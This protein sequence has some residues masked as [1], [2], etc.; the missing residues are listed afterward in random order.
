MTSF[1]ADYE[2]ILL[3]LHLMEARVGQDFKIIRNRLEEMKHKYEQRIQ[4][5]GNG[6]ET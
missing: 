5:I 1:N 4:Q 2:E 3:L 6:D